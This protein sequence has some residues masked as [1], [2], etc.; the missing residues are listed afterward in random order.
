MYK[1]ND[2]FPSYDNVE[3][4]AY[5]ITPKHL[6]E[7]WYLWNPWNKNVPTFNNLANYAGNSTEKLQ[8]FRKS[9][10]KHYAQVFT[11]RTES[12]SNFE[13]NENFELIKSISAI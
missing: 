2:F 8:Y 10:L 12:Y 1:T 9:I 13:Q 5:E 11:K 6:F 3:C 4:S 7:F